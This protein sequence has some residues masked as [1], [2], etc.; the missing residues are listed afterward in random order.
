MVL[1]VVKLLL[2]PAGRSTTTAASSRPVRALFL[3]PAGPP[4]LC[5][6]PAKCLCKSAHFV[7]G[8]IASASG[9]FVNY[10]SGP[11]RV[12]KGSP[13]RDGKG[14]EGGRRYRWRWRIHLMPLP[15]EQQE[16]REAFVASSFH[17]LCSFLSSWCS[18]TPVAN[19]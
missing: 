6:C 15:P 9:N 2:L 16:R 18:S 1:A 14:R 11:S 13:P 5:Y 4:L 19:E 8:E 3:L 7:S 12:A 10:D 17:F